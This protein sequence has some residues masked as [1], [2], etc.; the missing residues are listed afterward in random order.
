MTRQRVLVLS[1][2]GVVAVGI[3]VLVLLKG[4]GSGEEAAAEPTPTALVTVAP[5][6]RGAVQDIVSAYGV[7]Q[8]DPAG[9][10]TVAAPKASIVVRTLA[11]SGQTVSAGQALVEIAN[12]PAAELAY[13]QAADAVT[14]AEADLARVQR[15]YDQHLAATD[16]LIVAQ[17]ALAD[18]RSALAAQAKQK[19]NQ[20]RVTLTAPAAGV[21]TNVA[22]AAGDHVAQDAPLVVLARSGAAVAKL[23]LEPSGGRF[24]PGQ[25]VTIT[26][27]FGGP[28]TSSRLTMVGRAADQ[29]TKTLDALAPA[30][31]GLPIGAPVKAEVIT[32]THQGVL[33]PHASV[34]FDET[35]SHVFLISQGKA[36]RVFVTVGGDHGDS[37][38]VSGPLPANA[39]VAV[40]GAY[41]LQDGMAVR[42]RGR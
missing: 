11:R 34:V 3:L 8:A 5:L 14:A 32:G 18:A 6:R 16:Q 19:S 40:E 15:L 10:L 7:V 31:A 4:R 27:S 41:E 21:V 38:E 20:S 30:P 35:G 2:A 33:A 12:A 28:P 24:M 36:H 26:P 23:A 25:A 17:K 13:R 1:V 37:V 42:V 22:A 39:S 29:T 9:T